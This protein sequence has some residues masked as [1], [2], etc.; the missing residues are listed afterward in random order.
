MLDFSLK[1]IRYLLGFVFV[2]HRKS[3]V[4]NSWLQISRT[5]KQNLHLIFTFG[6]ELQTELNITFCTDIY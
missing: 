2:I 3:I 6:L 4:L 1:K 5:P